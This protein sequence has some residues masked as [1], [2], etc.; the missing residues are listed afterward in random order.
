MNRRSMEE[1][2]ASLFLELAASWRP[3]KELPA[4]ELI[5]EDVLDVT[6]VASVGVVVAVVRRLTTR[7]NAAMSSSS[8]GEGMV[9][10]G[11]EISEALRVLLEALRPG[12]LAMPSVLRMVRI[13]LRF[14]QDKAYHSVLEY[15]LV[16]SALVQVSIEVEAAT[17]TSDTLLSEVRL[18][19]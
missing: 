7:E 14:G 18:A 6:V 5:E 3:P 4:I 8:G 11:V 17:V 15:C 19:R 9:G 10:L 13:A 1:T 16:A 2:G 12:A